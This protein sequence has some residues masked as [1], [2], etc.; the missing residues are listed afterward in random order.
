MAGSRTYVLLAALSL[1]VC[2]L[3]GIASRLKFPG[4]LPHHFA[5]VDLQLKDEKVSPAVYYGTPRSLWESS[6][7]GVHRI[8]VTR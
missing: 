3:A 8:R 5:H 1:V 4:P 7:L 6:C 2:V